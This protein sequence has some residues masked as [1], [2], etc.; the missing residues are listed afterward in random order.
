LIG[1]PLGCRGGMFKLSPVQKLV[2]AK[3]YRANI[4]GERY[5]AARS[6]ER[7]TLASLF[8]AHL[9]ERWVWRGIEGEANAA[10]EYELHPVVREELRKTLLAR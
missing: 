1:S 5:R 10:H 3:V 8:R 2:L 7:V 4:K 9:L 6:G